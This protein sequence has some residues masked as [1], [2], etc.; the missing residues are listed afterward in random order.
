MLIFSAWNHQLIQLTHLIGSKDRLFLEFIAGML[1]Y[2]PSRRLT[3]EEALY[4]PFLEYLI[5][6]RVLGEPSIRKSNYCGQEVRISNTAGQMETISS[7]D[8]AISLPS[9]RES[10]MEKKMEKQGYSSDYDN[11]KHL[12]NSRAGHSIG[13]SSSSP[14]MQSRHPMEFCTFPVHPY[15]LTS[16]LSHGD[17]TLA[18]SLWSRIRTTCSDKLQSSE[19]IPNESMEDTI[20]SFHE[21]EIDIMPSPR[22]LLDDTLGSLVDDIWKSFDCEKNTNLMSDMKTNQEDEVK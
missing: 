16:R 19:W 17:S 20:S 13:L 8:S 2:D 3:P 6:M 11:D 21:H 7:I 12:E 10:S 22:K 4:H 14:I 15:H 18:E 5:P 1:H 9:A